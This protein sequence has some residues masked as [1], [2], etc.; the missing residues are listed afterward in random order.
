[1]KD[2]P[3]Y[4]VFDSKTKENSLFSSN[5]EAQASA[6]HILKIMAFIVT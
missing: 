4:Y 3:C 5:G 6:K 2:I 1:M